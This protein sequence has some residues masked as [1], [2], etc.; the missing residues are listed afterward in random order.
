MLRFHYLVI[1]MCMLLL[2]CAPAQAKRGPEPELT[3]LTVAGNSY[4]VHYIAIKTV[5]DSNVPQPSGLGALW[6]RLTGV[7]TTAVPIHLGE[8]ATGIQ[9]Q[10]VES[11]S[12]KQTLIYTIIFDPD[13]ETDVQWSFIKAMRM[14]GTTLILTREDGK[15]Y[16]VSVPLP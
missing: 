15:E 4:M 6:Q 5:P 2:L 11:P 16:P 10:L 1:S 7:P 8:H 14:E 9:A 12:K 13:L 3:P